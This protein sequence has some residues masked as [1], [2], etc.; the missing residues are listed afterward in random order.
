MCRVHQSD[1]VHIPDV[2][3]LRISN[4]ARNTNYCTGDSMTVMSVILT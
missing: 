2:R 4:S 3:A 1:P